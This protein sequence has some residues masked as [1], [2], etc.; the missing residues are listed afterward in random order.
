MKQVDTSTNRRR[1]VLAFPSEASGTSQGKQPFVEPKL[2]SYT[3][4][5]FVC[6]SIRHEGRSGD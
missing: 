4:L 1:D 2:I 6:L 5:T 3:A